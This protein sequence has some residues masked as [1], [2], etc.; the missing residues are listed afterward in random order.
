M[1]TQTATRRTSVPSYPVLLGVVVA[2]CT[3]G[4]ALNLVGAMAYGVVDEGP[5]TLE[6]QLTGVLGFGALGLVV[7]LLAA[8]VL[9]R[10][11]ARRRAGAAVLGVLAVVSLV[12]FFSG[13]PGMLGAT[14]A[15]LAG[16]TRGTGPVEGAPRAFGLVGLAIAVLNVLVCTVGIAVAWAGELV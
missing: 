5:R 12:F 2:V 13:L 11:P 8:A 9:G 7:S 3:G 1:T 14:A 16:L 15:Y 10:T 6:Q 4:M